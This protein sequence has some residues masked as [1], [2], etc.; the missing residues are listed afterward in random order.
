MLD[1]KLAVFGECMIEFSGQPFLNLEQRFGGDT[2]NTC[3]YLKKLS[4]HSGKVSYVTALGTDPL[5]RSLIEQWKTL[6]IDTEWVFT[7]NKRNVGIYFIENDDN[8]ERK[9]HYWR[10]DSAAKFVMTQPGI[11]GVFS[12]IRD[13]DAIFLSGISLAI[14]PENDRELLLSH[15]SD[16]RRYGVRVIFDGNYRPSLW[17]STASARAMYQK[18]YS[19]SDIALLT[20]DDEKLLWGDADVDASFARLSEFSVPQLIVKDGA[21]GCY[22]MAEKEVYHVRTDTVT[23]V[24]DTTAAGDSFNA[25]FLLA[26]LNGQSLYSCGELGN[27]V[28]GQVIQKQGA[29]VDL[30]DIELGF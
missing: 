7:D 24:V 25:G 27:R 16:L 22:C 29:I 5:S 1:F 4:P 30:G 13:F 8:G 15:L 18:L 9:F 28:A 21:N 3:A 26:H 6:N 17:P 19:L 20:F 23:N 2:L 10:N 11:S 14:L 12:S